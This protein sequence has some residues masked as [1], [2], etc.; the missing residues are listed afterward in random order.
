MSAGLAL[1]VL[2]IVLVIV[3]AVALYVSKRTGE[4]HSMWFGSHPENIARIERAYLL[5]GIA[6]VVVGL[7][8]AVLGAGSVVL[9]VLLF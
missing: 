2:G 8:I 9:D 7:F 5:A 3:G 6:S 4:V 1:G